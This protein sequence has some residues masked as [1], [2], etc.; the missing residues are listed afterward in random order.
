MRHTLREA[1]AGR[2]VLVTGHTGFKGGWLS[3]WLRR[4]GATVVGVALPPQER[5]FC[6]AVG[7]ESLIDSRVGDI[8]NEA[9]FREAVEGEDFDLVIHMAA[10]AVV[11]A[12]YE[13]PVD[14]YLTNVMGT[15]VVLEAARRMPSLRGV[16]V[17]T[18]DKCYENNEWV[19]GYREH[20]PMGGRDPYSS[21]KGCAELVAAAYRASFFSNPEGPAA[22]NG[23][24]R[25][26]HR[27]WRLGRRQAGSRPGARGRNA[28][29]PRGYATRGTSARGSMFW[30][31]C[32]ATSC[33]AAR[34]IDTGTGL[35]RRLELR[36]A[37]AT[38]QWT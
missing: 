26:C 6:T 7:L 2:R 18:S 14:T 1:L 36:P 37:T 3:L 23:A 12:S 16:I 28:D 11:R 25:Q 17:V 10:Q 4:L 19:W 31:P 30:S 5:S 27:R 21:S 13:A 22:R 20:D 34:L 38:R 32:A 33:S 8:R 35:C 9:N 24:R 29:C 15:A